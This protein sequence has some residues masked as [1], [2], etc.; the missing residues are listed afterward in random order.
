MYSKHTVF[1]N[2]VH[3]IFHNNSTIQIQNKCKLLHPHAFIQ[4]RHVFSQLNK[5]IAR[6]DKVSRGRGYVFLYLILTDEFLVGDVGGQICVQEGTKSQA[7]TPTAAEVGHI[8]ILSK[9]KKGQRSLKKT[10]RQNDNNLKASR[11]GHGSS[12]SRITIPLVLNGTLMP[13]CRMLTD[14]LGSP[15]NPLVCFVICPQ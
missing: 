3:F 12:C 15:F 13:F 1:V 6:G 10:Q 4:Y 2:I 14:L 11:K 7:I 9:K 8:N 5:H